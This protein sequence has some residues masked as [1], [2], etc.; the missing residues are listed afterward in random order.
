MA[1]MTS[2]LFIS[3]AVVWVLVFAG[4]SS[5]PPVIP[6]FGRPARIRDE[7]Y[8][9]LYTLADKQS[10]LDKILIIKRAGAKVSAEIKQIA[11]VFSQA[12]ERL[13]GF[14][15]EDSGL[16]FKMSHLPSLEEKTR[17]AIESTTTKDLLFSSGKAFELRLLLTQVQA[18]DYASHLA[19]Q[20]ADQDGNPKRKEFLTRFAK[21]CE[22][23]HKQVVDLLASL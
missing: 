6:I 21:Q 18:L 3:A 1:Y 7:G 11:E 23:H 20:L 10:G 19:N 4:C 9:L 16:S 14:A 15:K 8:S 12:K 22:Q 13:D 17:A 5:V 2:R